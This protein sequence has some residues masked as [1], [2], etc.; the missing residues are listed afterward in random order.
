MVFQAS[1]LEAYEASQVAR[2]FSQTTMDNWSGVLERFLA[3]C[4]RPAWEVT[5]E[6]VDRVVAGLVAQGLAASTRRGYVQAFKGFHAFLVARKAAEIEAAFGVR[7]VDPVDEFNAARHVGADS[8]SAK[9][10]P[11]PQRMEEFFDFLKDR[12][13]T[14]RKYVAA[15]R[16]YALFRTLYLAGLRAEEAASLDRSDVHFGRGTFGKLHVRFGKGAK[17]SGPRPR[18]VPML[19]GLDLVL[20]WYLADVRGRFP[21]GPVLLCDESGG[22]M[23]AA[24]IRNRLRHLMSVEGR[25]ESEWFSPHGMRR[26]CATH[27]Y[28]RGVDLVAIQQL[29]GHWTVASTMRYV[30]PS[31]TF[32]EDAYQR[33]ISSTVSELTG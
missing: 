8:A 5:R 12:V 24:T 21:D 26:A 28:E 22:R 23:A 17:G 11:S 29:L 4:G 15:G 9:P 14:A 6:D 30:R 3:A 20:R 18:W 25:P 13:A 19:D 16:D 2:G 7:L 10:P 33:A 1:C 32:I 27:N 31:E